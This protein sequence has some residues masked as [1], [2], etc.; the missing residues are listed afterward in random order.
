MAGTIGIDRTA[1]NYVILTHGHP[2]HSGGLLD[3]DGSLLFPNSTLVM[4]LGDWDLWTSANPD[5]ADFCCPKILDQ[6]LPIVQEGLN[7]YSEDKR[8][9]IKNQFETLF[10][11]VTL[12][13]AGGHTS[14]DGPLAVI[15][16][17]SGK[18]LYVLGDIYFAPN[19]IEHRDYGCTHDHHR[20]ESIDTRSY[21]TDQYIDS[22]LLF[23]MHFAFPGLGFYDSVKNNF[24][25]ETC[26]NKKN[27]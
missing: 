21:Y 5:W 4:G 17:S 24:I 15:I 13:R 12:V 19:H 10:P 11:G 20:Q 18:R 23:G 25:P 2:D 8:L 3:M 14:V 22:D 6:L 9:L 7:K 16:E 1:V 27:C 26:L